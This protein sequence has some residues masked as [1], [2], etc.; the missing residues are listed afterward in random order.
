MKVQVTQSEVIAALKTYAKDVL[1]LQVDDKPFTAEFKTTRKGGSNTSAFLVI[2]EQDAVQAPAKAIK[3]AA[4][5]VVKTTAEASPPAAVETATPAIVT[6]VAANT[7]PVAV[8]PVE[9]QVAPVTETADAT[10]GTT[11]DPAPAATTTSLFG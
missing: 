8:A 2:G 5:K 1:G 6:P 11:E 9:A 10:S 3:E 7:A 4:A